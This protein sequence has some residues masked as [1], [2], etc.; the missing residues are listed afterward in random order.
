VV[1]VGWVSVGVRILEILEGY[2]RVVVG[3]FGGRY[4]EAFGV[5]TGFGGKWF[6][7]G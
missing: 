1:G 6:T 4:R 5:T 3:V 7:G 2:W